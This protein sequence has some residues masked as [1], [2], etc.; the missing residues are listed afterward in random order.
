[1]LYVQSHLTCSRA[2]IWYSLGPSHLLAF[3]IVVVSVLHTCTVQRLLEA[4]Q[5]V[6]QLVDITHVALKVVSHLE[7]LRINSDSK[8]MHS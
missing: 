2:N 4:H 6:V 8:W 7:T 1:M 5:V 3:V